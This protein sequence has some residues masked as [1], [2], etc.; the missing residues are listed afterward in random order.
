LP[1][2]AA[3]ETTILPKHERKHTTKIRQSR[4]CHGDYR[5]LD[6]GEHV[7]ARV[8]AGKYD[9]NRRALR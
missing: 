9:N 5:N 6:N 8:G 4:S 3:Y 2:K 7:G 1:C